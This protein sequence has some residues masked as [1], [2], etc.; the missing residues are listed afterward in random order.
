MEPIKIGI[1]N[2]MQNKLETMRNFQRVLAYENI[3][4]QFYYSA[5][6]YVNRTLDSAITD[7]MKPLDLEDIK[8]LDGFIITGSPVE[9]LDF[10]QVSYFDEV[11]S[12]ID[13]LN[14]TNLPQ[15][16][17]CWGAMAALNR[18]YNIQKKL[19]PHK[20]FGVFQNQ[21]TKD[22]YI[23]NNISDNFPAPH[24]RYAEMD[25]E[26]IEQNPFLSINATSQNGLLTLVQS[27]NKNQTFIFSHLEYQR[28]SLDKEYRR[29]VMS[30]KVKHPF[31]AF[32]YYSPLD[33][34]P[35]FSWK[36]TQKN[37]YKNWL[38][39]VTEYKLTTC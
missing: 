31:P 36:E 3:E 12:L 2:L 28:E 20:V 30:P 38:Q 24:A 11:N 32:N 23:L 1:L 34:N 14:Q 15:L 25:H 33:E 13:Q 6:R 4:L 39:T 35:M 37:F 7:N 16:Y 26:E 18:I 29:E 8:T 19:L 5:T 9:K 17:V 22:S 21:I 10:P 27:N